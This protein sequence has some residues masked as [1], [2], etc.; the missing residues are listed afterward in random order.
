MRKGGLGRLFTPFGITQLVLLAA[1]GVAL[2]LAYLPWRWEH[3][4]DELR[5]RFPNVGR[6]DA[7]GLKSWFDNAGEPKPVVIDVRPQADYDFSHLP[8]AKRM[9]L[10]ET[11][12]IFDLP[13]TTGESL[14]IYDAVGANAF[15]V[16]DSLLKS[17]YAH[18]Q[19][20][21]GGIFEWA[22]RGLPLG[23]KQGATGRVRAGNSKFAAMLK[24]R[25]RAD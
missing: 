3:A 9:A 17:G 23:G 21:E 22:N 19:V 14:V 11:P 24:R 12:R 8:G 25:A 7:D 18:V 6:I 1:V 20:L 5:S 10:S 2:W 16:A 4:K 13:E 15:P